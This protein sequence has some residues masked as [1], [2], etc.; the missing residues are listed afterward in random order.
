MSEAA[1]RTTATSRSSRV[2]PGLHGAV[3]ASEHAKLAWP[4]RILLISLFLPW[5]WH[6]GPLA[7]SPYRLVVLVMVMPCLFLWI[8]GRAGRVRSADITILLYCLWCFMSLVVNHGLEG[9]IQQAG[10]QFIETAGAYFIARCYIRNADNFYDAI[11]LLFWIVVILFPFAILEA[12]TN[13]NFL[14]EFLSK[15]V[16]AFPLSGREARWG[17]RRVQGVLEHPILFGV[18]CGSIFALVHLVL[19]Y[20]EKAGRRWLRTG[21]VG[22]TA[23]LS[24][25][26]GPISALAAQAM[27]IFWNWLLRNYEYRWRLLVGLL[28]AMWILLSLVAKRSVPNIFLS[29]FS[30]DAQSAYFRILIW[31]FGTQS[32]LNHP[33]FGVG[34]NR[35]ERPSWMPS[36]IDMFWLTHAVYYGIPAAILMIVAFILPLLSIGF[37]KNLDERLE[38]YRTGYIIA[39]CSFFLAGWTVHFWNAPYV[40]FLFLLGSG[41]WMLDVRSAEIAPDR[42]PART[43]ARSGLRT[44]ERDGPRT[45]GRERMEPRH[46]SRPSQRLQ[47]K[48]DRGRRR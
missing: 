4:V 9:S 5:T 34:M 10:I 18:V 47:V 43:A 21:I 33:L 29:F 31:T 17:L 35:W 44:G 11:R 15:F 39:M 48:S 16:Q 32:A 40:L 12:V 8:T 3:Y 27:L 25:S 45:G 37:L 30:F 20:G 28:S 38:Q 22:A 1:V 14:L 26:A 41:L 13:R 6:I 2:L 7:I 46:R 23:L 42:L 24:L 36:S 19:G